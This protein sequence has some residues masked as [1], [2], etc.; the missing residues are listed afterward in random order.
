MNNEATAHDV[1]PYLS[2]E[3]TGRAIV[4]ELQV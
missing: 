2:A 4:A 1:Q 3:E